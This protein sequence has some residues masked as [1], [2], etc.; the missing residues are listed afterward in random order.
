MGPT[1]ITSLIQTGSLAQGLNAGAMINQQQRANNEAALQQQALAQKQQEATAGNAES[2]ALQND[3]ANIMADR[4]PTASDYAQLTLKYPGMQKQFKQSWDMLKEEQKETRVKQAS[5]VYAALSAD[6]PEIAK[7]L[8]AEQVEAAKNSG[9]ERGAKSAQV[10]LD[11]IEMNP[12]TAKTSVA[13]RLATMMNPDKFTET[14]TKLETNRRTTA[15]E[16]A[17]LT[18]AQAEA[19]K[20]ATAADF[21]ESTAVMDLQKKGW[22]IT[23]IQQDIQVAK[24]NKKIA[25]MNA[26]LRK[27]QLEI[28]RDNS[29]SRRESNLLRQRELEIKLKE[30]KSKRDERINVKSAEV[31]AARGNIDNMVNTL[32]RVVQTPLNVI[33]NATGPVDR[34]LP[35]TRKAT[36]DFEELISTIDAQSFLAQI[37]QMKGMGALSDS[38]GKKL[39]AALQNFSLRQSPERLIENVREA[40]RLLT[41][42]RKN[43]A[44]RYGVPDTIP[45][46]P[47]VQTAP[48]DIESLLQKYGGGQ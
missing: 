18:K 32:D 36:A 48:E 6:K 35:T 33:E 17:A 5:E 24:D 13:L 29:A 22:D 43:L 9:N 10:M 4:S 40:Q 12:D 19:D 21:A 28:D 41:K 34:W 23:K 15:G 2:E 30:M 38:E 11:L 7:D 46:T 47:A 14:F 16:G 25:L 31:E 44:Q 8:L 42:A 1:D 3:L 26:D 20:A 27:Q 45:D 39:A 37:P